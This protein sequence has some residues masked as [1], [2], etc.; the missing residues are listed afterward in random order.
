MA[1]RVRTILGVPASPHAAA[2]DLARPVSVHR[3]FHQRHRKFKYL[4]SGCGAHF[5]S[6]TARLEQ[7]A[8]SGSSHPCAG[9]AYPVQP[10]PRHSPCRM[11]RPGVATRH[12]NAFLLPK[13]TLFGASIFPS[14]AKAY[15]FPWA[16]EAAN[17]FAV[18]M[19]TQE[20]RRDAATMRGEPKCDE[21]VQ[22]RRR[23]HTSGLKHTPDGPLDHRLIHIKDFDKRSGDFHGCRTKP[24]YMG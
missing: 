5:G 19:G 9:K 20:T 17:I 16:A 2:D 3:A 6:E 11:H 24:C 10:F 1:L 15:N 23:P 7:L 4:K 12:A 22:F 18:G 8:L 21:Q 13:L 14:P